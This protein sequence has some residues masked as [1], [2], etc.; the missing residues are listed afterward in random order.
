MKVAATN[1][2][3]MTIRSTAPI[4]VS[5]S[6]CSRSDCPSAVAVSPRRMKTAEKEAMNNRL[7]PRTLRQLTSSISVIETPV[8]AER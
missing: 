1:S 4:S 5:R 7:G 3:P 8:T 6:W 2:T